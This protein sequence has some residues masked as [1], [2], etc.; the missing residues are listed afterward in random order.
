MKLRNVRIL[1]QDEIKTL[2]SM[3]DAILAMREAFPAISSGLAVAPLRI[4]LP[5]DDVEANSLIMPVYVPGEPFYMVKTV[6]LNRRNP[7]LGLP[8]IHSVI[9]VFDAKTGA[10]AAILDGEYITGLRTGAGSALAT[11]LLTNESSSVMAVF[12]TG[13]QAWFQ[14]MGVLAVRPIE[15]VLVFSRNHDRRQAF[16]ERIQDTFGIEAVEASMS[17]LKSAQIICT[18]TPSLSPLFELHDCADEV[19]INAVGSY[20]P[21]M[22]EIPDKIVR[23]CF[24]VV[25]S[26]HAALAEAGDFA[27]AVRDGLFDDKASCIEL[28]ELLNLKLTPES[29]WSLFKSVGNAVQ[30]FYCVKK[31]WPLIRR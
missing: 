29:K 13:P 28:G 22:I 8:Y 27:A 14:V 25:D 20:K 24:V 10:L 30:D 18:A 7:I 1:E 19:H 3:G 23:D 17:Q 6:S 9:Q 16:I 12:G 5:M 4:N 15:Q 11:S 31:L 26:R 21:D 2:I